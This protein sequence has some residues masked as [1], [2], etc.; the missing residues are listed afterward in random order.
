MGQCLSAG[1]TETQFWKSSYRAVYNLIYTLNKKSESESKERWEQTR[2]L[3]QYM[4][5]PYR[6]PGSNT[7]NVFPLPWDNDQIE[8]K[9]ET[10][11]ERIA[12]EK[13]F[14]KLDKLM[15]ERYA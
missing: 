13:H 7:G 9:E 3:C 11:E 2:A 1:W 10:E 6:K 12:R 5:A 8:V 15:R 4:I 14:E